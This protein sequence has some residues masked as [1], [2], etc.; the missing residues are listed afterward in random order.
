MV[1]CF[2][3][4]GTIFFGFAHEE[5]RV[6]ALPG[7]PAVDDKERDLQQ[8]Q[9][10]SR[11]GNHSF[12]VQRRYGEHLVEEAPRAP[13]EE[14]TI[15]VFVLGRKHRRGCGGRLSGDYVRRL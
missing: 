6:D 1:Q 15:L 7:G 14:G 2:R 3:E 5:E 11:G 8:V 4:V 13:R 12:K 10:R 9:R